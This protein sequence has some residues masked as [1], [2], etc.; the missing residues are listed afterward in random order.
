MGN[1]VHKNSKGEAKIAN[2]LAGAGIQFKQEVSFK[3][4]VG[5]KKVPLRF[6]FALFKN[7]KLVCL[8]DFDGRQHFEFVSYFYKTWSAFQKAKERDR[9]KNKF[10]L[11][12]NIPLIRVPYWDYDILTLQGILTNPQYKVKSI[13]HNDL[14]GGEKK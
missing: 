3:G 8:L 14:I 12:N 2:L 7:G 9:I 4:L 5:K 6:D 11:L 1:V 10:C 13:Y